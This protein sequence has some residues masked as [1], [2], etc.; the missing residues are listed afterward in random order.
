MWYNQSINQLI[1]INV[2]ASFTLG[3]FNST[4]KKEINTA[5][6]CKKC[7]RE[8]TIIRDFLH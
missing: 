8:T 2:E 5:V 6:A 7:G 1:K 4:L 3:Y